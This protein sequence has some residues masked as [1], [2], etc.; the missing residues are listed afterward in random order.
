MHDASRFEEWMR[1]HEKDMK[2]I[3]GFVQSLK[4][5]DSFSEVSKF[6][7]QVLKDYNFRR[8][9][10]ASFISRSIDLE[11]GK[12]TLIREKNG[13]FLARETLIQYA[14][15]LSL[16]NREIIVQ[17]HCK[18][19]NS[20]DHQLL[21]VTSE[22][23]KINYSKNKFPA[24]FLLDPIIVN[25]EIDGTQVPIW[26][27]ID[28]NRR[29]RKSERNI[30]LDNGFSL[31]EI[32]LTPQNVNGEFVCLWGITKCIHCQSP[33][34][35]S[36]SPHQPLNKIESVQE[37]QVQSQRKPTGRERKI[38]KLEELLNKPIPFGEY[39]GKPFRWLIGFKESYLEKLLRESDP[40]EEL[41]DFLKQIAK[42]ANEVDFDG[43]PDLLGLSKLI[44]RSTR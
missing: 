39:A 1:S 20:E 18:K 7:S 28:K 25:G 38:E 15:E 14:I 11:T 34:P 17:A 23:I 31:L 42:L 12:P 43:F 26:V 10:V 13:F 8:E 36:D 24:I 9:E 2:L 32:V 30:I 4:G 35:I 5:F 37:E 19:C 6:L 44:E 41:M 27:H 3:N 21:K 40:E 22:Q 29:L 16:N 33:V